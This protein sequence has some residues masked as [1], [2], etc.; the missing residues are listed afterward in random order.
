MSGDSVGEKARRDPRQRKGKAA[1]KKAWS[2]VT[3]LA[4]LKLRVSERFREAKEAW[5]K[6]P[7]H[8]GV[9]EILPP[10]P[11]NVLPG[12][13][14]KLVGPHSGTNPHWT[15]AVRRLLEEGPETMGRQVL[16]LQQPSQDGTLPRPPP[17][18]ERPPRRGQSGGLGRPRPGERAGPP[19]QSPVG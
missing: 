19:R 12:S 7:Q 13:H 14:L 6:D 18:P 10:P 4:Y 11:K 15:L 1:E 17:L 16:V 2:R 9:N 8:H 3:S 5:H